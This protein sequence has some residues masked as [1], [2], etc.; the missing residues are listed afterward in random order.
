M[1]ISLP[2][3]SLRGLAVILTA[4]KIRDVEKGGRPCVAA[5]R[6]SDGLPDDG[7]IE[8]VAKSLF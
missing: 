5:W 8:D 4:R 1:T 2:S 7:E 6:A 3:S